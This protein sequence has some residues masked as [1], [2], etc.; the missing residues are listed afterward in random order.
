ME[1]IGKFNKEILR[2]KHEQ[3]T[4]LKT[5]TPDQGILNFLCNQPSKN[6]Y[7]LKNSGDIIGT[8]GCSI[9]KPISSDKIT[10]DGEFI[11]VNGNKPAVVHQYDR[12]AQL[13]EMI[14]KLYD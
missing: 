8:V 7:E 11:Y 14:S 3:R 13:S 6:T 2:F 4:D 9:A 1:I 12:S 5:H 10:S